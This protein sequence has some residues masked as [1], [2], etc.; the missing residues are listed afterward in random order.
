MSIFKD[1]PAPL[2]AEETLAL[3]TQLCEAT[4]ES[5]VTAETLRCSICHHS[6]HAHYKTNDGAG[7]IATDP[8]PATFDAA[9]DGEQAGQSHIAGPHGCLCPGFTRGRLPAA[10]T[11]HIDGLDAHEGELCPNPECGHPLTRHGGQGYDGLN[12]CWACPCAINAI[13]DTS[14]FT[15]TLDAS[16]AETLTNPTADRTAEL[17]ASNGWLITAHSDVNHAV[18]LRIWQPDG[19]TFQSDKLDSRNPIWTA[20]SSHDTTDIDMTI[21]DC[22]LHD[23]TCDPHHRYQMHLTITADN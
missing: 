18:T 8:A 14:L 23:N 19:P 21:T 17:H 7:C 2:T 6:I 4:S 11:K 15:L 22:P 10:M 20:L 9:L 13:P 1:N 5:Q 16:T 3:Y 12:G